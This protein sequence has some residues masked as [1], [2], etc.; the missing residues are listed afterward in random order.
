M[1]QAA[2]FLISGLKQQFESDPSTSKTC[3]KKI[4]PDCKTPDLY[5]PK[6]TDEQK[7]QAVLEEPRFGMFSLLHY[8]WYVSPYVPLSF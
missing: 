4:L 7:T 3:R 5:A 6:V 2:R 8:H 1:S